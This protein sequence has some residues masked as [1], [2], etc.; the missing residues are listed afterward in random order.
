MDDAP[1]RLC[2]ENVALASR[3]AKASSN[4]DFKHPLHKLAHINDGKYGNSKSWIAARNTG[5]VQIELPKAVSIERIEWARDPEGK[6]SDRLAVEYRIEVAMK[7]GEWT[8]VASS[9]G[10][11][12]FGEGG[13]AGPRYKFSGLPEA[14]AKR[15]R[16]LLASLKETEKQLETLKASS[17][18][19]AGTFSQPGPTHRLYRGDPETKREEV[20]PNWIGHGHPVPPDVVQ[21]SLLLCRFRRCKGSRVDGPIRLT[22]QGCCYFPP[23][24]AFLKLIELRVESAH[25]LRGFSERDHRI[26][27]TRLMGMKSL[28]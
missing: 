24:D 21:Y 13:V 1:L 11:K 6:Y 14:E 4:G 17:K 16:K 15:G 26:C 25:F 27:C 7:V 28:A 20:G 22:G 5:W 8:T 3:G 19:Y 18:V 23:A 2:G 9:T 10:R 12:P